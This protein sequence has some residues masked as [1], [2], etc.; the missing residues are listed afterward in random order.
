MPN[1]KTRMRVIKNKINVSI[2]ITSLIDPNLSAKAKGIHCFLLTLPDDWK[3]YVEELTNHFTDGR[4]S[5]SAG[6]NELI[7]AGYVRRERKQDTGGLFRGYEYLVFETPQK[8]KKVKKEAKKTDSKPR[9]KRVSTVNGFSVNGLTATNVLKDLKDKTLKQEN[10]TTRKP[11]NVVVISPEK[12]EA[13]S[14]KITEILG[15]SLTATAVIKLLKLPGG[16]EKVDFYIHNW[17]KFVD[18]FSMRSVTGV[19]IDAVK[20]SRPIPKSSAAKHPIPQTQNYE[21]RQ[22][23]DEFLESL[24]YKFPD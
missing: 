18:A 16:E 22:Y 15:A 11:K 10:T 4:D 14:Q 3:I 5:I 19:F 7:E 21:Q 6:I 20:N 12:I 9:E 2:N 1:N 24:Y 17:K 8:I 23:T 13:V